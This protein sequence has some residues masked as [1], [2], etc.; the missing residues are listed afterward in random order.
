MEIDLSNLDQKTRG[1]VDEIFR[2]DFD[3]KVLK[4]IKRQTAVAARNYLKRPR[5]QDGF[6]ERTLEI[7]AFIDAIWR[8]HYGPGYS[9]DK[10]LMKFLTRRNPEIKV[11]SR[12]TKI[13]V[14]WMAGRESKRPVG[15]KH[16][17]PA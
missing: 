1:T 3:L 2:K 16:L 4:A 8:N 13:Q 14:G 11:Q 17:T 5:A 10:D 9:E 6:G 15:I 12:G 7:D